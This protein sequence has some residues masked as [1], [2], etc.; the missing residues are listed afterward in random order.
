MYHICD[1]KK[2]IAVEIQKMFHTHDSK[3]YITPDIICLANIRQFRVGFS[4]G[5][6]K[7]NILRL[8]LFSGSFAQP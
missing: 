2:Y 3:E 4:G 7:W 8:S 1:S 6:S 5:I